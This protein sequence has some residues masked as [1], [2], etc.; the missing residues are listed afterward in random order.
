RDDDGPSE[1]RDGVQD[2]IDDR[3]GRGNQGMG[4]QD[5][6]D[7]RRALEGSS[8]PEQGGGRHDGHKADSGQTGDSGKTGDGKACAA[9]ET[10]A[11]RS[12]ADQ[13][14]GIDGAEARSQK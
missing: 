4:G 11:D 2:G 6:A 7:H 13:T 5:A 3:Q 9:S 1:S 14:V 12:T 8:G 10:D